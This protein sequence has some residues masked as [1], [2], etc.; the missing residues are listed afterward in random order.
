MGS[1]SLLRL[2]VR[3]LADR[4]TEAEKQSGLAGHAASQKPCSSRRHSPIACGQ[5]TSPEV[6]EL[7]EED[8]ASSEPQACRKE[9]GGDSTIAEVGEVEFW[10]I[11]KEGDAPH[12]P[13]SRVVRLAE[14][15]KHSGLAGHAASQ[16]PC[17]SRRH[18]PIACG[19]PTSPEVEELVEEDV[20]SSEP[21]ACRKERGGDS[22]I[23]EVGEVEFWI[24][25]KEGDA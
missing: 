2:H 11:E 3:N 10:I 12:V 15:E 24:I 13:A 19:Q 9:R 16:K 5:P 17:S 22:T 21:Q 25:E 1:E 14:A 20:A 4:L 7:V 23:A 8:V 18:S 6:E